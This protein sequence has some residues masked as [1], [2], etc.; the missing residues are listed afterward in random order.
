[1]IPEDWEVTKLGEVA[2]IKT[3]PFGSALHEKDYVDDGTPIMTVEHLGE[4]GV[5][6]PSLLHVIL[7]GCTLV[8]MGS[9]SNYSIL[10]ARIEAIS[11][12]FWGFL[13]DDD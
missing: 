12:S 7:L 4:H 1:M 6:V 13:N 2:H 11:R 8:I 5:V 3:G 10:R 9:I